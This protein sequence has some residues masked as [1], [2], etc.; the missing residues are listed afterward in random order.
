[1]FPEQLLGAGS[2]ANS[3]KDPA[4]ALPACHL[5]NLYP[6]PQARCLQKLIPRLVGACRVKAMAGQSEMSWELTDSPEVWSGFPEEV[7]VEHR[8]QKCMCL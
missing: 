3:K 7:I 5:P 6:L 4:H 1:M 8:W 2:H